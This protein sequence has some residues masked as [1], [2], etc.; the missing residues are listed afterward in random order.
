[1]FPPVDGN[2]TD[3]DFFFF[4]SASAVLC[5]APPVFHTAMQ[6]VHAR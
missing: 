2:A 5:T 3:F 1:M 4:L 6:F